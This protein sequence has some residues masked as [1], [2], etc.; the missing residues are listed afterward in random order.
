MSFEK[1]LKWA[2][3]FDK[4]GEF[5][6]E[7]QQKMFDMYYNEDYSLAEIAGEMGIS[8]Q[9]VADGIKKSQI[10]LKSMEEKLGLVSSELEETNGI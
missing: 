7:K 4:Y 1:D 8:R 10:K 9:G 2:V 5:L 6:T 3:Y